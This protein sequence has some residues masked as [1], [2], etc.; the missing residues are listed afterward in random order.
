MDILRIFFF[1][2]AGCFTSVLSAVEQP[3]TEATSSILNPTVNEVQ[4]CIKNKSVSPNHTSTKKEVTF[5]T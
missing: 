3:A 4:D 2:L 5:T 1:V